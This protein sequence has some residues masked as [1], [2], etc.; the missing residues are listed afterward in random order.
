MNILSIIYSIPPVPYSTSSLYAQTHSVSSTKTNSPTH[1]GFPSTESSP[2]IPSASYTNNFHQLQDDAQY[3]VNEY[4]R[5]DL[6]TDGSQAIGSP[7]TLD[8]SVLITN[9]ISGLP[10]SSS[11]HPYAAAPYHPPSQ[12]IP[13][14][15][16]RKHR[17]RAPS[18]PLPPPPPLSSLPPAPTAVVGSP[19]DAAYSHPNSCPES[20]PQIEHAPRSLSGLTPLK[21]EVDD[22]RINAHLQIHDEDMKGMALDTPRN[23]K[24]DSHP[25]PP[26]PS[27]TSSADSLGTP[28][29]SVHIPKAPPSPRPSNG[30]PT[31][32]RGPSI[33]APRSEPGATSQPAPIINPTTAQGAIHQRRNKTSLPSRSAS[34]DSTLSA[35]SAPSQKQLQHP[36]PAVPVA[37]PPAG[38]ARSSSQPG[39]RPSVVNAAIEQRPP[40]P[41][42]AGPNAWN[43]RKPSFPSKLASNPSAIGVVQPGELM[44]P[45]IGTP[46][47]S[48]FA[49][50][51]MSSGVIPFVPASPLPP[52][53]PND[54]L[55]QPY[56]MMS[57]LAASMTSPSGGYITRRLHVPNDVWAIPGIKLSNVA[58]K[59]RVLEILLAALEDLQNTS[60]EYFGAGNV[61]SGMAM[62]I[63]SIGGK[64]ANA[65][66]AKLEE[67]STLCDGVAGNFGKKLGVGEGFVLKKTTWS[68]KLS[69]RFDKF[70]NGKK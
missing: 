53:P 5:H 41:P 58:E 46:A 28:R 29:T 56:Y 36:L 50:P 9:S 21:E 18:L 33:A 24:R 19:S 26:I 37:S 10:S 14:A 15:A 51:S 3:N 31:R 1:S 16:A 6:P 4:A 63:G 59:I 17:S 52:P 65:W 43:N 40:L 12:P 47:P 61:S 54:P 34:P 25:L 67:F 66:V 13:V 48:I 38:R 30:V 42:S 20:K 27:P 35:G 23:S 62:G 49:P 70:T 57:L 11:Q 60:S 22:S 8:E 55:R 68:D 64:E 7:I 2:Q 39:R 69:R 32:P 44:S 45:Q